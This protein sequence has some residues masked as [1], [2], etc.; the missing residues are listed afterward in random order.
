MKSIWRSFL[1]ALFLHCDV[2]PNIPPK[3][4]NKTQ[5]P[6]HIFAPVVNRLTWPFSSGSSSSLSCLCFGDRSDTQRICTCFPVDTPH[7]CHTRVDHV[8]YTAN[9][10]ARLCN[11]C[12]EEHL[13]DR[14][15]PSLRQFLHLLFFPIL[16]LRESQAQNFLAL[17]DSMQ[18]TLRVL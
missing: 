3:A 9:R 5:F 8:L 11:V 13:E 16:P 6:L 18:R 2:Q 7:L 1:V 12:R 4:I 14:I 15:V 10:Y 17:C